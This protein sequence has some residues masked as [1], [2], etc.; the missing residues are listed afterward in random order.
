MGY[1]NSACLG[2]SSGLGLAAELQRTHNHEHSEA[3]LQLW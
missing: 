3:A 1:G 2:V